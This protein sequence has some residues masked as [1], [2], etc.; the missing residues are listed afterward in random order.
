[1]CSCTFAAMLAEVMPEKNEIPEE[2]HKQPSSAHSSCQGNAVAPQ[3]EAP[4]HGVSGRSL[5]GKPSLIYASWHPGCTSAL[6]PRLG[7]I[8]ASIYITLHNILT[9]GTCMGALSAGLAWASSLRDLHGR[10]L[11]ETCM[12]ALSAGLACAPSLRDLHGRSLCGTCMA[13]VER[14]RVERERVES[15]E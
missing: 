6:L 12:G 2:L 1:M 4:S 9:W 7:L 10:P 11:C 3:R 13:R 8:V 5:P 15:R 14:E